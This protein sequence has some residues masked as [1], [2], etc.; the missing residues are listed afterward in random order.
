MNLFTVFAS[1]KKGFQ[2]EYASAI[3]A[4]LLNPAMDHG[5]GY[6]FLI[7]Y[8]R[9]I[10]Q[11][12]DVDNPVPQE[13][14]KLAEGL[15]T[16]LR[17][18][19]LGMARCE[20]F[21]EYNV[22]TAFID[23][24]V[25]ITL[26]NQQWTFAIENKIFGSSAADPLQLVRE[27]NGLKAKEDFNGRRIAMIFLV[28][29][30]NG[31]LH[32][33]VAEEFANLEVRS[34]DFRILTTWQSHDRY[35]S[36]VNVLRTLLD[37]EQRGEIEPVH[38]EARQ[39]LMAFRR[40]IIDE[41]S[42][43]TFVAQSGIGGQNPLTEKSLTYAELLSEPDGWVGV[44]YGSGGLLR[45]MQD[46]GIDSYRRKFQFTTHCME[47]KRN[48]MPVKTFKAIT[49]LEPSTNNS[50][51]SWLDEVGALPSDL[52]DFLATLTTTR[53]YIGIKGGENGF[54]TMPEQTVA[55]KRW[56]VGTLKK[57]DSWLDSVTF[58]RIYAAI[59]TPIGESLASSAPG[60][61]GHC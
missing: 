52:I 56:E 26:D 14:K 13:L 46:Q 41:F 32:H 15:T 2:E 27:Y 23:V 59:M 35:P 60:A 37:K 11:S 3:L 44:Q 38:I 24:V 8:L 17:H 9:A 53:F 50:D 61:A 36:I 22:E 19:S 39:M 7:E 1:A 51:I 57:S 49:S 16:H 55:A 10:G 43:Y 29:L 28:P 30:E 54:K 5:L 47:N 42:G 4:W 34:P 21:L 25:N 12:H 33:Y 6:N 31:E 18:N 58:R 40:F 45:I 20:T 48:W